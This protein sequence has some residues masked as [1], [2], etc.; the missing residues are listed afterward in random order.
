MAALGNQYTAPRLKW[1]SFGDLPLG[2]RCPVLVSQALGLGLEV[3]VVTT[4]EARGPSPG[5]GATYSSIHGNDRHSLTRHVCRWKT[6]LL[7]PRGKVSHD[8]DY[9]F[10]KQKKKKGSVATYSLTSIY[11]YIYIYIF[12]FFFNIDV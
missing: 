6:N 10:K 12:F 8:S 1:S 5:D 9:F 7:C 3:H 4:G 11:I 2:R